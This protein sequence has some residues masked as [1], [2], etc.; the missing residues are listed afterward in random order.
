[1]LVEIIKHL[2]LDGALGVLSCTAALVVRRRT[3]PRLVVV[4]IL[5]GCGCGH[6]DRT[7]RHLHT[8]QRMRTGTSGTT[9]RTWDGWG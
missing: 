5:N 3:P 2:R 1:M 9:W 4:V 7:G 8:A 6:A